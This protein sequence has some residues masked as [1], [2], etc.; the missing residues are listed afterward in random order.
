MSSAASGIVIVGAGEAGARA[1]SALREQGFDGP[2]TLVG[3][4]KHGPYERPPLSKAVMAADTVDAPPS[5]LDEDKLAARAITHLAHVRATHIDTAAH[6]VTL[7]DGRVLPY[8]KLLIAT[9]AGPRR[10]PT[11]GAT[12][13][14]VLYL[15]T[16]ADALVLRDRLRP[17]SRIAVIGG[18]FIG[19]EIAASAVGRGCTVTVI[20]MAPR[21]LM[22]GVPEA[23]AA[24]V[25]ARHAAAGVTFHLGV[26]IERIEAG[27]VRLR[28]GTVVA[29]DAIIAGIGAIPETALAE[30]S[31]LAVE[32]GVK[33]NEHLRTSDPDV[34]AAGDC[35]SFPHPLYQGRRLRL[36]AW[37]NAQDQGNL[38][39]RNMLGGT[40]AFAAVPWFWSDQY[41]ETLQV[42][43]LADEGVS[44]VE[45]D[46]G[47]GRLYF[48]LASDGRLVGVSGIGP[49]SLIA[50]D[51]RLG[52][53][54]IARSARPDP[55]A[56]AQ[57]GVK[58][59]ALL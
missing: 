50:R 42:A 2:V 27:A 8:A 38:A 45:R 49:N 22:R 40:E 14:T 52:E 47:A 53:M 16:F 48:H 54:L 56:L 46:L 41:D 4:E 32:N 18:G 57:P 58:L 7:D 44:T 36:E 24:R 34:Y 39:A 35:C 3:D 26:S 31:G 17:G 19:L 10:L 20:E 6:R 11:P 25:M 28:D 21:I 15:R 55:A 13:D 23:V 37:R 29:C 33:V 59:K 9:G 30:A 12:G 5:I 1:A 43:G 51:V